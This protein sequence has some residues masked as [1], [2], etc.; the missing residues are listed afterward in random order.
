MN[1]K[2]LYATLIYLTVQ[3]GI[4]FLLVYVLFYDLYIDIIICSCIIIVGVIIL[5]I[6]YYII[7]ESRCRIS[8][9]TTTDY[10]FQLALFLV[11][12]IAYSW[13]FANLVCV[14]TVDHDFSFSGVMEM[15]F[16]FLSTFSFFI[17]NIAKKICGR[18]Q[19]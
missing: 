17:V 8:T 10:L 14:L 5:S 1:M 13:G 11:I 7:T 19:R 18:F 6:L 9:T 2:R 16:G 12:N 3:W 4:Y 15:F